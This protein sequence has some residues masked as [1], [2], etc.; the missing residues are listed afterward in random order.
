MDVS[1][2]SP[3]DRLAIVPVVVYGRARCEL[4]EGVRRYLE[5]A[6]TP[7]HWVDLDSNPQDAARL[8]WVTGGRVHS[9]VVSVGGEVL[10]QPTIGE[11]DWALTRARRPVSA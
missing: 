10:V 4:S 9:P 1:G 3:N 2:V 7:Y 6:E 11:L 5:R 8:A